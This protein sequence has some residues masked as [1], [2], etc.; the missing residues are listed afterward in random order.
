VIAQDLEINL[1]CAPL[2]WLSELVMYRTEM[3]NIIAQLAVPTKN[4]EKYES[5]MS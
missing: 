2:T 4:K 1:T 5:N 3:R